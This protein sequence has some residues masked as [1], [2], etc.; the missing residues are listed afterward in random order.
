[1]TTDFDRDEVVQQ[2]TAK[3]RE[4]FPKASGDEIQK[5]VGEEV[6]GLANRPVQDY[7]SVLSERAARKRLKAK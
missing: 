2:V 7:V 1:M 5:I 6:D 3:L 4:K